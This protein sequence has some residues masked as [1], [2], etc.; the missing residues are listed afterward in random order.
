MV[1]IYRCC[2]ERYGRC[3]P[4]GKLTGKFVVYLVAT[5]IPDWAPPAPASHRAIPPERVPA[6]Q[7]GLAVGKSLRALA[8]EMGVSHET[9]RAALKDEVGKGQGNY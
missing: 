6:F 3:G 1:W 2:Q 4:D 5:L 8:R 7:E 9:I